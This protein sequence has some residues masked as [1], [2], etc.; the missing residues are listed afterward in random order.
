[1]VMVASL[2]ALDAYFRASKTTLEAVLANSTWVD[3]I[4]GAHVIPTQV[5]YLW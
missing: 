3:L 5:L 4:V 2:Q 1:M